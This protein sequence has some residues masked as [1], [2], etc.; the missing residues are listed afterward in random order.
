MVGNGVANSA[1]DDL[2]VRIDFLYGHGIISR[3]LYGNIIAACTTKPPT[4]QCNTLKSDAYNH[5]N[6]IDIYNLYADCYH[7]R[8]GVSGVPPC[9]DAYFS[10]SYLNL[11]TVKTA[12]HVNPSITWAICSDPVNSSYNRTSASMIPIHKALL[13]N[14]IKVLIYSGDADFSVP[15]TDSEYWTSVQM[16]LTPT[17]EWQPWFFTDAEGQQV[18]GFVTDYQ[19]GLTFAT[20]KGAGHMVP[21]YAPQPSYVFFQKTLAGVPL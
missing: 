4:A 14:N 15:Y 1:A 7:Q 6:D 16:G 19:G 12:I 13:A 21:Q 8:G 11:P 2:T 20:I 3:K 17:R 10:T 9:T 18:A 5:M